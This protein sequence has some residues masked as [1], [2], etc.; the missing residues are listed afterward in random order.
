MTEQDVRPKIVGVTIVVSLVELEALDI[1]AALNDLNCIDCEDLRPRFTE[2]LG[3]RPDAQK[4]ALLLLKGI[5]DYAM[6]PDNAG[7]PF[8]PRWVWEDHRALVPSDLCAAQI[9]VIAEFA[10]AIE[11]VGL[12]ARLADVVWTIQRK[13]QDAADLAV[14][15]YCD[16]IEAL[17]TGSVS[18]ASRNDSA[19]CLRASGMAVRA[20][21]ISSG[22]GWKLSS[23]KRTRSL[24]ADL[25]RQ[26]ATENRGDDFCRLAEVDLIYRLT[27]PKT[28][29]NE[30]ERMVELEKYIDSP[31]MRK[32]LLKTAVRAFQKVGD[33]S[34]RH[35]CIR[36][37]ARCHEQKAEMTDSAMVKIFCLQDAFKTLHQAPNTNDARAAIEVKLREVQLYIRDEMH[38]FS[39]E[40]DF[41]ALSEAATSNVNGQTFPN[42]LFQLL[43]CDIVPSEAESKQET[44]RNSAKN[45]LKAMMDVLGLDP[46]DRLKFRSSGLDDENRARWDMNSDRKQ[47]RQIVVIGIIDPIKRKLAN[48]HPVSVEVVDAML[49]ESVFV[50]PGHHRIFARGIAAFIH[51]ENIDAASILVPQLENTLR[52]ILKLKGIDC[53]W[54]NEEGI[55]SDATLSLLLNRDKN[56]R[57][58]LE[59]VFPDGYIHE[60]ESVFSFVGGTAVRNQIAHGKMAVCNFWDEEVTYACWLIMHL[61]ARPM[62][63]RWPEVEKAY[64]RA[65]GEKPFS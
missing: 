27:P 5:C 53:T 15:A 43:F 29:A 44:E 32:W 56:W 59:K 51:G 49:Q 26:A 62:V 54:R 47:D 40:I 2:L 11:N 8:K 20:S 12:R 4:S 42:A 48:E 7:E 31:D 41:S 37:I 19:W 35:R 28:V 22:T 24:I 61:I 10:P 60:I 23:A 46:Q 30:A 25:V 52:H 13:R 63:G 50:P 18:L 16:G 64:Y 58:E 57:S 6:D 45:P 21:R 34:G 55:Q 38:S 3:K 17:R 65:S 39:I 33:D 9:K 36:G 1:N 14:N